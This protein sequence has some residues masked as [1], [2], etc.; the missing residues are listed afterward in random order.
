MIVYIQ[1][2]LKIKMNA[3]IAF[4]LSD[5]KFNAHAWPGNYEWVTGMCWSVNFSTS[6]QTKIHMTQNPIAFLLHLYNTEAAVPYK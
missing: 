5:V 1:I 4:I 2:Q 3:I 6:E